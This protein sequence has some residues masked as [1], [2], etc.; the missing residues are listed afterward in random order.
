MCQLVSQRSRPRHP[1]DD[2]DRPN[3][4]GTAKAVSGG[5]PNDASAI[6]RTSSR[7]P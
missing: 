2:E 1:D 6:N 4:T 7:T 3:N 5:T